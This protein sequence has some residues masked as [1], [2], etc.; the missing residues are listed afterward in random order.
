M[1]ESASYICLV[2]LRK[3]K[4]SNVLFRCLLFSLVAELPLGSR[5]HYSI[6]S[7][8]VSDFW[9][10]EV[11]CSDLAVV[12]QLPSSSVFSV[13]LMAS[14]TNLCCSFLD[15]T[16]HEF[17]SAISIS[18]LFRISCFCFSQPCGFNLSY[19]IQISPSCF[20]SCNASFSCFWLFVGFMGHAKLAGGTRGLAALARPEPVLTSSYGPHPGVLHRISECGCDK[21][22]CLLL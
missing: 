6:T 18:C 21:T 1:R 7:C 17:I 3:H 4:E 16:V 12:R 15:R 8:T 20:L 13:F 2:I 10:V 5:D 9:E 11:L 22:E 14:R 19:E